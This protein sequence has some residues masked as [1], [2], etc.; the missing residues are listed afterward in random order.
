MRPESI[1]S[2]RLTGMTVLALRFLSG[3]ADTASLAIG[4]IES[5]FRKEGIAGNSI[6]TSAR[7]RDFSIWDRV[8]PSVSFR[9]RR[10]RLVFSNAWRYAGVSIPEEGCEN[11]RERHVFKMMGLLKDG[12]IDT[13]G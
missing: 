2:F 9:R 1:M 13:D 8:R 11:P 6:V 7:L 4:A 3:F 10:T 5:S 12:R